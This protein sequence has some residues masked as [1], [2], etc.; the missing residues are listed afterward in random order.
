M[1][2]YHKLTC[3]AILL[4]TLLPV[5]IFVATYA[6]LVRRSASGEEDSAETALLLSHDLVGADSLPRS[7]RLEAAEKLGRLGHAAKAGVPALIEALTDSDAL[8]AELSADA[9]GRVG[10]NVPQVRTALAACFLREEGCVRVAAATALLKLDP[11]DRG[12][13]QIWSTCLDSDDE[14]V[15]GRVLQDMTWSDLS[16]SELSPKVKALLIRANFQFKIAAIQA[17]GKID[18]VGSFRELEPF[19]DSPETNLARF[20]IQAIGQAGPSARKGVPT[21]LRALQK[22]DLQAAAAQALGK[23]KPQQ[24]AVV[25]G[26]TSLLKAPHYETQSVAIRVLR[27]MECDRRPAI[28]G[29]VER[30][31]VADLRVLGN[32]EQES[33]GDI[34][35]DQMQSKKDLRATDWNEVIKR[36]VIELLGE[37]GSDARIAEPELIRLAVDGDEKT[38]RYARLALERIRR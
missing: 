24:A 23:I 11:S 12:P 8:V 20:A 2:K 3:L 1:T 4:G 21:L 38:R 17:L 19:V 22:P 35:E 31:R 13:I 37:I 34:P 27:K 25:A 7:R 29:L 10:R 30:L 16:L 9:L 28:E 15:V 5:S 6:T 26:L 18:P 14:I 32:G 36:G 33:K